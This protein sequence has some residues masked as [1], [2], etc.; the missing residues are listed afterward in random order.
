MPY[1]MPRFHP[2]SKQPL[3]QPERDK[4]A[5]VGLRHEAR[6]RATGNLLIVG[7]PDV[8]PTYAEALPRRTRG[9]RKQY[10]PNLTGP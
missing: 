5:P 2:G 6:H 1:R 8:G 10:L 3:R 7:P 4:N 9:S